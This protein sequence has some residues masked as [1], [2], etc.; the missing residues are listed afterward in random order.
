M[1]PTPKAPTLITGRA[2][3]GIDAARL[4]DA[5]GRV[6]LRVR[7]M[8]RDRATIALDEL[9]EELGVGPAEGR[10]IAEAMVNSRLLERLSPHGVHY[11]IT[12]KFRSYAEAKIVEPLGRERAHL[13]LEH[14]AGVAREF[15]R[16]AIRNRYEIDVIVVF[17]SYMSTDR[18]LPDLT[19]GI[20]GRH[21][22]PP[23]RGVFGRATKQ[24]EGTAEIRGLFEGL[25]SYV[26]VSLFQSLQDV[27]RPFIVVFEA[28]T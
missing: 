20:T 21:R 14:M 13:L 9:Q 19:I 12:E 26:Q 6:L 25:S 5:T 15:N 11:S 1:N 7:D 27:P 8:P 24:T 16:K 18:A 10:S 4:R 2:Y 3:F 22:P 17:G 28:E 23:E